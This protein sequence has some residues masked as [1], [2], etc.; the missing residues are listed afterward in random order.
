MGKSALLILLSLTIVPAI[1]NAAENIAL[2]LAPDTGS[3]KL[4]DI[5]VEDKRLAGAEPVMDEDNRAEGW[6]WLGYQGDFKGFVELKEV[7]KDLS[8][9]PGALVYL[10][11]SSK[12]PVLTV[13]TTEDAAE[14]I[15]A[16]DWAEISF[17]KSLPVYFKHPSKTLPVLIFE[18]EPNKTTRAQPDGS[19]PVSIPGI[20]PSVY[21]NP[22]VEIPPRYFEGILENATGWIGKKP[23]FKFQLVTGRG[24]RIAY[25]DITSL[26]VTKPIIYYLGK[27]VL[28]YGGAIGL[29]DSKEIVVYAR[30]M[31]LR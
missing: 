16:E 12:S 15:Y 1:S 6:Y 28:I 27:K 26:L 13:I 5:N 2:Y 4:A 25:V 29:D 20:V 31:R 22:S 21:A 19:T 9:R 18:D 10:R 8:V 30:T 7:A 11:A 24:K 14:L 17:S 3:H 23:K